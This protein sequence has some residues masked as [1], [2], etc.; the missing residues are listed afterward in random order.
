M[1]D[2][3]EHKG[4]RHLFL[5]ASFEG[6]GIVPARWNGSGDLIAA[7]GADGLV[8]LPVGA[9]FAAGDPARFTPYVG[10][11]L[12]ERGAMPARGGR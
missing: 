6:G 4:R 3:Y 1:A 11:A 9:T 10:H 7:A 12:A 2:A 5:P 8:E